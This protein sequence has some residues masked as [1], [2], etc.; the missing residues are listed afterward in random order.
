VSVPSRGQNS[1][2]LDSSVGY[3]A[4]KNAWCPAFERTLIFQTSVKSHLG[5]CVVPCNSKP[6]D[7]SSRLVSGETVRELVSD[8][9]SEDD[10]SRG[11]PVSDAILSLIFCAF[12]VFPLRSY[13]LSFR[14]SLR[15]CTNVSCRTVHIL[16]SRK[17]LK[18][19]ILYKRKL[20][21]TGQIIKYF[22]LRL[23]LT[24]RV[25]PPC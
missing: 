9:G 2:R 21:S 12:E 16:R 20:P 11:F 15:F 17:P 1:A 25:L 18:A 24:S 6:M 10:A 5:E 19:A 7:A 22:V 4:C 3:H 14:S 8:E 23:V 13:I